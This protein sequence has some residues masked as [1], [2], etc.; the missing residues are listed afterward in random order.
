[1]AGSREKST[2]FLDRSSTVPTMA[3]GD[4]DPIS[5][6][7][8]LMVVAAVEN[9]VAPWAP[10]YVLYAFL[11]LLLPFLLGAVKVGRVKLPRPRHWIAAAVIAVGLQLA[12]RPVAAAT[13]LP[14]MF[15]PV[16]AEA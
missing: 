12:F 1:M 3:P 9:T 8:A 14:A 11:T 2:W 10:F 16:F 13:D 15:A 5:I 4:V 6:A 7:L